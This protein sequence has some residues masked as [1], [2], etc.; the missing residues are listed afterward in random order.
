M[1]L[2]HKSDYFFK[3]ILPELLNRGIL[4]EIEYIGQG[5]KRRFKLGVTFGQIETALNNSKGSYQHF[6]EQFKIN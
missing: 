6:I 5:H 3:T 4:L 2:G 1:R